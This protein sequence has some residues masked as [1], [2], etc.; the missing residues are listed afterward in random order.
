MKRYKVRMLPLA[1]LDII[2]VRKWYKQHSQLLPQRFAEQVHLA[3]ERIRETPLAYAIRYN[4]T[5]IAYINVFPY[6][7]HFFVAEN[8]ICHHRHT[9]HCY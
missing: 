6:G 9:S 8:V 7:I 3:I 2:K 4:Q 5:R 1:R